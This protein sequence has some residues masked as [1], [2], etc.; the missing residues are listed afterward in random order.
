ME[1][2]LFTH[3]NRGDMNKESKDHLV[4]GGDTTRVFYVKSAYVRLANQTNGPMDGSFSNLWQA[5]AMPKA[6]ITG[7]RILLDRIPTSINLLKRRVAINSTI[8]ALCRESEE[9]TQHLF[10]DCAIA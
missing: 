7:W 5:K 10:L 2:D 4:W 3:I 9:S 6:L 1:E 8:C